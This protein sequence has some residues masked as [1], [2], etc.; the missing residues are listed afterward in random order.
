MGNR[1]A[2]KG[3]WVKIATTTKAIN[4]ARRF[5]TPDSKIPLFFPISLKPAHRKK[6]ENR[7]KISRVRTKITRLNMLSVITLKNIN[8]API[9]VKNFIIH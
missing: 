4:P 6:P 7:I 1:I 5:A 2:T 3:N 9:I 8:F